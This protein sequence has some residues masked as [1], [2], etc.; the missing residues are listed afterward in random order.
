MIRSSKLGKNKKSTLIGN[1]FIE[2]GLLTERQVEKVLDYQNEHKELKFAE[3][4]DILEMCNKE[5]LLDTLS[6]NIG[7]KGVILNE[8]IDINPLKYLPRDVIINY[9]VIPF[10]ENGNKL[11]LAFSDPLDN[12]RVEMIRKILKDNGY[13]IEVYVTLYTSIMKLISKIK[14]IKTDYID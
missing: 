14:N 4:V 7:I 8:K 5:D 9:K 3:I 11:K 12:E 1:D 13:E 10:E 2:R 6:N